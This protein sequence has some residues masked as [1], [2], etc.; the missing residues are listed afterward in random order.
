MRDTNG[1]RRGETRQRPMDLRLSDRARIHACVH[2]CVHVCDVCFRLL[3]SRGP[4]RL[5]L[6]E[7][8]AEKAARSLGAWENV[9]ISFQAGPFFSPAPYRHP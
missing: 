6:A 1:E 5:F 2:A 8:R 9:R 7:G 4:R 3:L